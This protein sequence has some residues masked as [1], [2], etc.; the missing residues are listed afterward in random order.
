MGTGTSSAAPPAV[1][2]P[3]PAARNLLD[4][5]QTSRANAT[6]RPKRSRQRIGSKRS[7]RK[8]GAKRGA[9]RVPESW[10]PISRISPTIGVLSRTNSGV[11]DGPSASGVGV[12]PVQARPRICRL[13]LAQALKKGIILAHYFKDTNRRR[14]FLRRGFWVI[15]SRFAISTRGITCLFWRIPT[16]RHALLKGSAKAYR[17]RLKSGL[18]RLIPGKQSPHR[19]R[20]RGFGFAEWQGPAR[21]GS[22]LIKILEIHFDRRC[23]LPFGSFQGPKIRASI[24]NHFII[25]GNI[26]AQASISPLVLRSFFP[27]G[28]TDL[29]RQ[30]IAGDGQPVQSSCFF[31]PCRFPAW[32][33]SAIAA[34]LSFRFGIADAAKHPRWPAVPSASL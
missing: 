32:R 33:C 4:A 30:R 11:R 7:R 17:K 16:S 28:R 25:A 14:L 10:P 19:L 21:N 23:C 6:S 8:S 9:G 27:F 24:L 12:G 13:W 1:A 22:Q 2:A 15:Q 3:A 18:L 34:S 5:L 31:C 29:T 20:R 26:L